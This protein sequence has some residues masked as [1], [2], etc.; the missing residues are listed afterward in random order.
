MLSSA[1]YTPT[2]HSKHLEFFS[3]WVI[4][5]LGPKP[6]YINGKCV[7]TFKSYMCDD[8][9]PVEFSLAWK[10]DNSKPMV[11]LSIEPLPTDVQAD[12][13]QIVQYGLFVLDNLQQTFQYPMSAFA[14]YFVMDASLF[15][16][17][18]K[19]IGFSNNQK[20]PVIVSNIFLGFD[21]L[22]FQ[23]Q[24]KAYCVLSSSL[25]VVE[26][27]ALVSKVIS[28]YARDTAASAIL[29]Y[30]QSKSADWRSTYSP[31]PIIIGVDCTGT[32][33]ARIKIYI[34]YKVTDFDQIVD[35]FTL[36][37][38]VPVSLACIAALRD[39]WCRFVGKDSD[40]FIRSSD[41]S[42]ILFYYEFNTLKSLP[43]VKVYMPVRLMGKNDQAIVETTADWLGNHTQLS[44]Y[45]G[46]FVNAVAEIW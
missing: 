1:N 17:I 22:P 43:S 35:Q 13:S 37:G 46:A 39:L 19:T 29:A 32:D 34:R 8:H 42:G 21:L 16:N 26:K 30:F 38:R 40:P 24:L 9:T 5:L 20:G 3:Q 36:G 4:P 44:K 31:D 6:R 12:Q 11:R 15:F 41:T 33:D 7:P 27:R 14:N 2:Q 45:R 10:S 28:A 25:D 23:A 18:L